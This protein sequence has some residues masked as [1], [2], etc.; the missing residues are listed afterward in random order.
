MM[1][2]MNGKDN[3]NTSSNMSTMIGD[4][5]AIEAMGTT[6]VP[7]PFLPFKL[8]LGMLRRSFIW[9]TMERWI[10]T[11]LRFSMGK[12]IESK[13]SSISS[14]AGGR[15]V[16]SQTIT[17]YSLGLCWGPISTQGLIVVPTFFQS[18]RVCCSSLPNRTFQRQVSLGP[19]GTRSLIV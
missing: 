18:H 12:R 11:R 6:S 16:Q 19:I 1:A 3:M 17:R 4:G 10:R 9:T 14:A 5:M 7:L 15:S 8:I 13:S 2:M